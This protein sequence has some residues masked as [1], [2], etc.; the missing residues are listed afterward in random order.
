MRKEDL[1]YDEYARDEAIQYALKQY[2]KYKSKCDKTDKIVVFNIDEP[3]YRKRLY[4]YDLN[5]SK[6]VRNHH[7]C[8][9][10][11]SS[12]PKDRAYAKYFSNEVGSHKSSI[13]AMATTNTYRGKHGLSLKLKGLESRNSNV[14]RRYIVIHSA[15]YC[16]NNHIMDRGRAGQSHGCPA[17]DPLISGSLISDI[18][19]GTFFYIY[20]K[21]KKKQ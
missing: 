11:N 15:Y 21:P 8:H 18:K 14:E 4:V 2:D 10:V 12:D 3:S 6:V 9:G 1:N 20:H 16:T 19:G 7:C 17:V 5:I 13:G